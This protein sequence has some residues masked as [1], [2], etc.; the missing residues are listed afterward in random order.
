MW[1]IIGKGTIS[2]LGWRKETQN[3]LLVECLKDNL[4]I[5]SH[6]VDQGYYLTLYTKGCQTRKENLGTL[7]ENVIKCPNKIFFINEIKGNKDYS[8]GVISMKYH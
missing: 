2:I 7:V 6:I 1:S 8:T 4:L 5:L 3:V